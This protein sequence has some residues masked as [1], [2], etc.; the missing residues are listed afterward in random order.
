MKNRVIYLFFVVFILQTTFLVAQNKTKDYL[1]ADT[2]IV[3]RNILEFTSQGKPK[4]T[5]ISYNNNDR[6]D[7]ISLNHTQ[8]KSK[9]IEIYHYDMQT[10]E[11]IKTSLVYPES[12]FKDEYYFNG[13]HSIGDTVIFYMSAWIDKNNYDDKLLLFDLKEGVLK[14]EFT[15]RDEIHN[16]NDIITLPDGRLLICSGYLAN[17]KLNSKFLKLSILN[18]ADGRIEKQIKKS[19]PYAGLSYISKNLQIAITDN[20][21]LF[22]ELGNYKIHEY[23]FNLKHINT[24]KGHGEWKKFPKKVMKNIMSKYEE[25]IER[26]YKLS[27][28]WN[29]YNR[30]FRIY[31]EDNTCYVFYNKPQQFYGTLDV[32]KK[33]NEKWQLIKENIEDYVADWKDMRSVRN[34]INHTSNYLL[35]K[36][37][38]IYTFGFGVPL[39]LKKMENMTNKDIENYKEEYLLEND[40]ILLLD[41]FN[42]KLQ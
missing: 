32:W 28:Y 1:N 34:R 17:K 22:T 19:L 26:I 29:D 24:I 20:S 41:I 10:K 5:Y 21:I 7:I 35:F 13:I 2:T 31:V 16:I 6:F 3:F 23:D 42:S 30:I 38:K 18:P 12:V 36:D 40:N 8:I 14:N 4:Y 27:E 33:E 11:V 37:G 39:Q 25:P 15:Y 9:K